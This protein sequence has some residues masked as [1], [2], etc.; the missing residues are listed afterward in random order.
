[1]DT[2]ERLLGGPAPEVAPRL[3]GAYVVHGGVTIELTEVEAYAG[4]GDPASHA[5]RGPTPRTEVMFG[6]PAH[7]YVYFVYGM[8]WAINLVCHAEGSAGAVLLRA[9]NVVDGVARARERRG[10]V[11]AHRLASGPGNLAS[12]LGVDRALGGT[13]IGDRLAVRAGVPRE[14]ESGPRVGV[15]AAAE[16]PWRFWLP[17]EASVSAYR[18]HQPHRRR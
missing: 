1:M 18:R 16:V 9:G 13:R 8:H 10:D 15:A 12:A 14:H 17:G 2:L 7:V 11:P 4:T 5:Y 3:L 6:P